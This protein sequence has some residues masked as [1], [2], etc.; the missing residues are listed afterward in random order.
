MCPWWRKSGWGRPGGLGLEGPPAAAA[1]SAYPLRG[2]ACFQRRRPGSTPPWLLLLL[3][4]LLL[5][6]AA[7]VARCGAPGTAAWLLPPAHSITIAFF[8]SAPTV[9]LG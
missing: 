5:P 3:L 4:L 2:C 6:A 7:A 1:W 8:S 9:S